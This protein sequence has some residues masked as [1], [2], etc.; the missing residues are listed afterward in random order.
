M[1]KIRFTF[2]GETG[3]IT[4]QTPFNGDA[5]IRFGSMGFQY[6]ALR[7]GDLKK[8]VDAALAATRSAGRSAAAISAISAAIAGRFG[9]RRPP[10]AV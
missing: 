3:V 2:Q 4:L 7:D 1:T 9:H 6:I 8:A 10:P 5:F